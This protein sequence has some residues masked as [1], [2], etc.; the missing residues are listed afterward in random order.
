LKAGANIRRAADGKPDI[1]GLYNSNAGGA[2]YGLE[3]HRQDFLTP[4]TRGV[5][6]DP[7]DR[8][9]PYKPWAREERINRELPHRG[10]DDPTAHC[11]VAGVPRS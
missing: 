5:V 8:M 10:Y 3:Q 9:L 7:E 2:N 6:V 1:S 4:G 11:F